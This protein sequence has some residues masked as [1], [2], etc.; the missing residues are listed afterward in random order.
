MWFY[1]K[2]AQKIG[3]L[4]EEALL[5]L[6]KDN[7]VRAYDLVWH[8][9]LEDWVTAQSQFPELFYTGAKTNIKWPICVFLMALVYQAPLLSL[10]LKAPKSGFIGP[11]S[12]GWIALIGSG[13]F[14][15]YA[16][17]TKGRALRKSTKQQRGGGL[18][19]CSLAIGI[20]LV[21]LSLLSHNHILSILRAQI[22]RLSMSNYQMSLDLTDKGKLIVAG[23][24]GDGFTDK[25]KRYLETGNIKEVNITSDGGL[26]LESFSAGHLINKYPEIKVIAKHKCNSGCILFLLGANQRYADYNLKFGFHGIQAPMATQ[27]EKNSAAITKLKD[28]S[29]ALMKARQV[30]EDVIA[31]G[32]GSNQSQYTFVPATRLLEST[33]LNGLYYEGNLIEDLSLLPQRP[34][35]K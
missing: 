35:S 11:L 33:T 24:I 8:P 27:E 12:F 16:C 18:Y 23:Y 19:L 7:T 28:L 5:E 32:F 9:S 22:V 20:F 30:P 25:L 29:V 15:A 3:P 21:L 1:S 34:S 13:V 31:V 14:A 2:N 26:V 6:M 4:K 17:F 10:W